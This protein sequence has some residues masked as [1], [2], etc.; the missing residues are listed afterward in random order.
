MGIKTPNHELD[1]LYSKLKFEIHQKLEEFKNVKEEA[2]FYELVYCLCTPMSKAENALVVQKILEKNKY[3]QNNIDLIP[4]LSS[5][6]HYIRFHNQKA[7]YIE[8]AKSNFESIL[9]VIKS[10]ATPYQKR[11][12]LVD[13]VKGFGYKEASHF[14]RNIG[15]FGLAILDRHILRNLVK[16]G[17]IPQNFSINSKKS[18]KEIEKH[19]VNL[20][21]LFN[22]EVEEFDLL[23]WAKETGKILK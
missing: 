17:E 11:D 15:Y 6:K 14:L 8:E 16:F 23:L 22:L 19:F 12:I 2:Y 7:L 3:H 4:I 9:N 18:Y 13:T 1:V 20:S 5:P 21:T 10:Q